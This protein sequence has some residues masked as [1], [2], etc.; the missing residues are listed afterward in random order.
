MRQRI[1][2]PIACGGIRVD[3]IAANRL[4]WF[5][6]AK[7]LQTAGHTWWEFPAGIADAQEEAPAGRSLGGHPARLRQCAL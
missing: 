3:L 5:A 4:Q 2:I 7:H 1:L 6:E